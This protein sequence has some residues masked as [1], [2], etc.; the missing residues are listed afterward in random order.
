VKVKPSWKSKRILAYPVHT[1]SPGHWTLAI[2][3]DMTWRSSQKGSR[4]INIFHFD[5]LPVGNEHRDLAEKF[6]RHAFEVADSEEL[7][8]F[9]V[10]IPNQPAY[11]NDCGLYPSHF[12]KIF[13]S[14]IE[15][16]LDF[17]MVHSILLA[18]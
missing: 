14:D 6:G 18:F 7:K 8:V 17:C 3:V 11:S 15:K 13:L 10:P 16:Y 9:E 2:A 12:L 1:P 4:K 5:S